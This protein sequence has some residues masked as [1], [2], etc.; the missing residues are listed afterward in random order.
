MIN[1]VKYKDLGGADQGCLKAKY[2]FSFA[3]YYN[4]K[5][6]G[7]GSSEQLMTILLRPKK[8]LTLTNITIWKLLHMLNLVE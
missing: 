6:I 4:P 7:F 1:V 8:V 5:R 3:S 2:H